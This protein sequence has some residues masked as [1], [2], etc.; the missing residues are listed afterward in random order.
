[1]KLKNEY[2]LILALL[3]LLGCNSNDDNQQDETLA[4]FKAELDWMRN[5]GG[6][7]DD[8]AQD[9]ITTL[10]GGFAVLGYTN[11]I[12]GIIADKTTPVNDYWLLKFDSEG[13][14]QWN[15]T[16][17]GS[18]DDRGQA[19][20]QSNDGSYAIAGY[21]MSSDGD[22]S[23][24]QGFHDNW[25]L[26][27]NTSGEI[28]WEKSFGYAGHDHA[29]DIIQ[30]SDGGYFVSGFLD[31]TGS[32][33]AGNTGRSSVSAHG[34]GEF[35]ATRLNASGAIVWQR[36]FG[37]TNND[38]AHAVVQANDGGFVLAGYTESDDFDISESNGSYDFWALKISADGAQLW[39]RTYGG[40]GID[41]ANAI[42]KT[43]DNGYIIVG[44]SNSSD[45]MIS[46]NFGNS[47]V[48]AIK[49]NDA[50]KMEWERSYGGLDFEDAE[51]ITA[52][53]DGG[54][55]ITGNSKSTDND[56]IENKGEN[57]IWVF[58]I[59]ASGQLKWQKTMGGTGLDLGFDAFQSPNGNYVIICG[60]IV[61]ALNGTKDATI[62]KLK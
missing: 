56:L 57:D 39:E 50:G 2:I 47:D 62:I 35:W 44:G 34:V 4:N 18:K 19:L 26:K 27:L 3:I 21:S 5:Y 14:L 1:M 6:S 31:V 32:G 48:W 59:N 23:A 28:L 38:R 55:L 12:D 11:S 20:I 9:I 8:T 45:G 41:R 51:G 10:D 16:Y 25:I 40:S 29:Y 7:A 17:G 22:A 53:A 52:T 30:T 43:L 42:V 24:N 49:I 58:K 33:G 36:Y 46:R 60:E 13:N 54:F 37:G 61:N 15:K